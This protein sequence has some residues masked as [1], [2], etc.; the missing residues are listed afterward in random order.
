MFTGVVEICVYGTIY[1]TAAAA[2]FVFLEFA[3]HCMQAKNP[4]SAMVLHL[5]AAAEDCVSRAGHGVGEW[6]DRLEKRAVQLLLRAL[7]MF[8]QFYAAA[9]DVWETTKAGLI[10]VWAAVVQTWVNV[11]HMYDRIVALPERFFVAM[12]RHVAINPTKAVSVV[13]DVAIFCLILGI[14]FIFSWQV[15]IRMDP[16]EKVLVENHDELMKMQGKEY[17]SFLAERT[18]MYEISI[19][20]VLPVIHFK[21]D[22]LLFHA[23]LNRSLQ[24]LGG[25]Y[26]DYMPPTII[27]NEFGNIIAIKNGTATKNFNIYPPKNEEEMQKH[28]KEYEEIVQK[29]RT[30]MEKIENE[31]IHRQNKLQEFLHERAKGREESIQKY[32][33]AVCTV[34][35]KLKKLK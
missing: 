16:L 3:A 12:N 7:E 19:H 2:V 34:V 11:N 25:N 32:L 29:A 35:D 30:D 17:I 31:R 26:G 13:G 1:T 22:F 28:R 20:M 24:L 9:E 14:L 33:K 8:V 4:P 23:S 18:N 5:L 6:L 27:L 15:A 10:P 21:Q